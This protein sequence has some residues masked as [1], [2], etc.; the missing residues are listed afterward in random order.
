M[1]RKSLRAGLRLA[2]GI[3][4][5][6]S[7]LNKNRL[8]AFVASFEP[9]NGLEKFINSQKEVS[10]PWRLQSFQLARF[11]AAPA[12]SHQLSNLKEFRFVVVF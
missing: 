9:P 4:R 11:S 7:S 8:P 10:E 3:L 6:K 12:A 1:L 5:D 2:N